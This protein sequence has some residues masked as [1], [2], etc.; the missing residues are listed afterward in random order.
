MS[1]AA[2]Q[3]CFGPVKR[4]T[5]TDFLQKVELHLY[6]QQELF[7]ASNNLIFC[8]TGMY[9]NGKKR[10]IAAFFNSFAAMLQNKMHVFVAQEFT[11][12]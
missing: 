1:L 9:V 7:P 3:V 11:L 10:N 12:P 5:C 2:T 6:F 4:A 8:K